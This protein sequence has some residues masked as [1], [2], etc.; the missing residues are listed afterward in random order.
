L[1]IDA[2]TGRLTKVTAGVCT[3]HSKLKNSRASPP[4]CSR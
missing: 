2:A 1:V 3:C 4:G